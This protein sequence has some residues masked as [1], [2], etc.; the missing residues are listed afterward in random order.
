MHLHLY[1]DDTQL[2][3]TFEPQ[4]SKIAMQRMEECIKEIKS[5]MGKHLLKLSNDKIEFLIVGTPQ[6][7][8]AFSTCTFS[9]GES[10]ILPSV[11]AVRNIGAMLDPA[12]TMRS[13][14]NNVSKSCYF[15]IRRLS[16]IRKYL[17]E[18]SAKTLVHAFVSSRLDNVNSILVNVPKSEINKLQLIQNHAA[19]VVKKENKSCHIT[20]LLKDLHWLPIEYRIRFKTILFVYKSLR[21]EGPAYL[22]SLLDEFKPLQNLRSINKMLLKVPKWKGKYG[23]RAFSV[24]GPQLWNEL[25]LF[26]KQACST[27]SFKHL[28]KTHLFR[29]AF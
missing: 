12:L 18:N 14:I 23:Q 7:L 27:N 20:P 4:D 25:P 15:Q 13:H 3:T 5:W 22:A 19:R 9:V 26:I 21:G 6:R 24:A 28:L 29:I 2:Y 8:K 10:E 1:A 11:S 17:T 16:K